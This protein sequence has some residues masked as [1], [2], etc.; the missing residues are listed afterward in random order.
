LESVESLDLLGHF[1]EVAHLGLPV[2]DLSVLFD[3]ALVPRADNVIS[4]VDQTT[5]FGRNSLPCLIDFLR[6]FGDRYQVRCQLI[7]HVEDLL[8][9]GRFHSFWSCLK[10]YNK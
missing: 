1:R 8:F 4:V 3:N 10:E 6:L 7:G 2:S 5:N 9:V